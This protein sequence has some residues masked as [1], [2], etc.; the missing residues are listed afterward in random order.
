M[1]ERNSKD[2]LEKLKELKQNDRIS[3]LDF[4]EPE[5]KNFDLSNVFDIDNVAP[6]PE[7]KKFVFGKRANRH[8]AEVKIKSN[9]FENTAPEIEDIMISSGL[10]KAQEEVVD[11]TE[12]GEDVLPA[13][14]IKEE[15]LEEVKSKPVIFEEDLTQEEQEEFNSFEELE[16]VMDTEETD[17]ETLAEIEEELEELTDE[18]YENAT[19]L[20]DEEYE[21]EEDDE[22][23]EI[24]EEDDIYDEERHELFYEKA[25][26]LLSQYEKEEAYLEK[27]SK[28]GYHFVR[29]VGKKSYFFHSKPARYYYSINYFSYEP[30][31]E[32]WREWEADGWKLVSRAPSNKRRDAGWLVFRNTEVKGKQRKVI[33]NDDEKYNFYRKHTNSCRSTMFFMFMCMA[34]CAVATLMQFKYKGY[35]WGFVVSGAV[36]L[37]AFILFCIYGRMLRNS[38]KVC[39]ALQA[40]IRTRER[41]AA[42]YAN[43]SFNTSES[44]E[45]LDS[46]WNTLETELSETQKT[47]KLKRR[48]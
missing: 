37:V 4:K 25:K 38:K 12:K 3:S 23:E 36:F 33:E 13:Y 22:N 35:V 41:R 26:F 11:N 42:F 29:R 46:D 24:E 32:Q 45:E 44:E 2:T 43:H 7:K 47:E 40:K 15:V 8:V 14:E 6:Q 27:K 18:D 48:R 31:A 21:D 20:D 10:V 30:S 5:L 34:V 1:E 17:P 19:Y 39:K 28:E 9:E 16:P